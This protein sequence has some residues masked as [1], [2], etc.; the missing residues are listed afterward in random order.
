MNQTP[1]NGLRICLEFILQESLKVRM[2]HHS[3]AMLGWRSSRKTMSIC[4]EIR[5]LHSGRSL[6]LALLKGC[7][8]LYRQNLLRIA[9]HWP[10][11]RL[12]ID[13]NSK[14]MT[15]LCESF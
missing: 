13:Q 4:R 6:L 2:A 9:A 14:W 1:T 7:R 10:V 15:H 5:G 12:K 11:G 8:G 3:K